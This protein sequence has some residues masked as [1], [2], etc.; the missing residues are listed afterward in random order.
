MKLSFS[1]LFLFTFSL[2]L[3][4]LA[5]AQAPEPPA[6]LKQ[7]E[8]DGAQLQ[9]LGD[10][11][12]VDGWIVL[13]PNGKEPIAPATD[14]A[15]PPQ[16]EMPVAQAAPTTTEAPAAAAAADAPVEATPEAPEAN[17][18]DP[19]SPE[20]QL[21]ALQESLGNL[22]QETGTVPPIVTTTEAPAPAPT[23]TSA[24]PTEPVKQSSVV[25]KMWNAL[26]K[27]SWVKWGD[28]KAPFV[29][30]YIDAQCPFSQKFLAEAKNKNWVSDKR[31]QI[32]L[33][34]VSY[35]ND[36]SPPLA[37]ELLNGA[38]VEHWINAM[39]SGTQKPDPKQKPRKGDLKKIE[40]NFEIAGEYGIDATPFV[41]YKTKAGEVK[42]IRGKPDTL[43]AIEA[44][45][46]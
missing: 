31:V 9:Y 37:A 25:T 14:P 28:E 11:R 13:V 29:Y 40:R 30:A 42:I 22:P 27:T 38:N 10:D 46:L 3:S 18:A 15:M 45:L 44:D 21:K 19:N 35:A 33:I 6:P 16:P 4:S 17:V 23:P 26:E 20:A 41:I 32:R 2:L 34:P 36:K 7:M 43:Y 39:I 1:L 5:Y 12:G 24:T 8:K